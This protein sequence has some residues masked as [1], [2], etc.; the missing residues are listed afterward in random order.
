MEHF[1]V[2]SSVTIRTLS[3]SIHH[4]SDFS[5]PFDLVHSTCLHHH[6]HRTHIQLFL[7]VLIVLNLTKSRTYPKTSSIVSY[8]IIPYSLLSE[9]HLSYLILSY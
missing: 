9:P 5:C 6:L 3:L 4:F 7:Y 1:T 8:P 2:V